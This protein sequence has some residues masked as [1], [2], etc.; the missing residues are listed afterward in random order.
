MKILI[1]DSG[2]E[3]I[4][5]KLQI[6]HKKRDISIKY[7]VPYIYEENRLAKREWRTIITIKDLMLIDSGL[8]NGF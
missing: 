8:P 5:H 6:F 7:A 3:F 2:E 1:V 4:L